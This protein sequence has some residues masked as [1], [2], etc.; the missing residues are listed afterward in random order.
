MECSVIPV[1]KQLINE[2]NRLYENE[3]DEKEKEKLREV[4]GYYANNKDFLVRYVDRENFT[5]EA[6]QELRDLGTMESSIHNVLAT[7]M[8]GHGLSW[9]ITG[10]EA[11]AKLLCLNHSNQDLLQ[12][13][14]EIAKRKINKDLQYDVKFELDDELKKAKKDV[15]EA[16][17]AMLYEKNSKFS[18][19]KSNIRVFDNKL[20][21][22]FKALRGLL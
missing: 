18:N 2:C 3:S 4:Y 17:R 13:V 6:D 5:I 21:Q 16:V 10:A 22:L 11:M 14:G 19:K 9:S 20:T 7:R 12:E 8:K 15:N 1:I